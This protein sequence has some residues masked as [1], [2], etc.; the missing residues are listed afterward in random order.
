VAIL[1]KYGEICSPIS[2]EAKGT[3]VQNTAIYPWR[4][5]S[6]K[7]DSVDRPFITMT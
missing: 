7:V 1:A 4:W 5:G 2:T 3:R 6:M